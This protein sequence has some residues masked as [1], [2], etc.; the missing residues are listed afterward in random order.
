MQVLNGPMD[1]DG[2]TALVTA[3]VDELDLEADRIAIRQSRFN[4]RLLSIIDE[5]MTTIANHEE[6]IQ[7]LE[8][9]L[10]LG[11]GGRSGK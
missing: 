11:S 9:L 1:L 2:L 8:G 10:G 6:R 3:E 4:T 5:M 7:E